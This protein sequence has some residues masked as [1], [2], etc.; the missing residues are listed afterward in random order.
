MPRR[1]AFLSVF[2]L[3]LVARRGRPDASDEKQDVDARLAERA[4]KISE[5]R[6]A[7]GRSRASSRGHGGIPRSSARSATFPRGCRRSSTTSRSIAASSPGLTELYAL[8][9]RGSRSCRRAVRDRARSAST[10][11]SSAIYQQRGSRRARGRSC[12][13]RASAT[14]SSSW[15]TSAASARRTSASAS[16]W[17]ELA[18]DMRGLRKRTRATKKRVVGRDTA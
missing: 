15:T 16:P 11:A 18:N 14:C 4:L 5:A 9:T 3:L 17:N 13:P 2:L 8:Q 1:F 10:G 7:S 6:A 12:R